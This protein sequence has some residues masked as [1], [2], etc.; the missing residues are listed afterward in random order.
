MASSGIGETWVL[1]LEAS[2]SKKVCSPQHAMRFEI[3]PPSAEDH[4]FE[5]GGMKLVVLKRQLEM[6]RGTEID[7]GERKG[8]QGFI[9]TS[10]NL[11]GD[12]LEKWGPVLEADPLSGNE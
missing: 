10:P 2:W 11:K 6:L 1:R 8:E 7:L 3:K 5:S 9:I 4:S 12:L